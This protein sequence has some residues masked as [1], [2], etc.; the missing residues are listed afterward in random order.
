MVMRKFMCLLLGILVS[1][2]AI[3]AHAQDA[4]S[5]SLDA[6]LTQVKSKGPGYRS[7]ESAV[8]GLER[9]KSQAELV[10]SPQIV[11]RAV[12]VDDRSSKVVSGLDDNYL[13]E[14]AKV[15]DASVGLVKK[16]KFG[17]VV[18]ALDYGFSKG[19]YDGVSGWSTAPTASVTLPLWRDFM[20]RQTRAQMDNM[21]Y[22][23][24]SAQYGSAHQRDALLFQAR[25]TYWGLQLTRDEVE[26]RKDTLA[27]AVSIVKW[28]QR[29]N[30]LRLAEE[31]EIIQARAAKEVREME[32]E[33]AI[34]NER[35][36][37]VAFNR[38]R[39]QEGEDVPEAL[40]PLET[41]VTALSFDWPKE[42]P[43]RWDLRG[44]EAK[45]KADQAAWTDAKANAWPDLKAFASYTAN[46]AGSSFKDS[47]GRSMDDHDPVS[48]VGAAIVIPLDV[49]NA[50][51]SADGYALNYQASKLA[52]DEKTLAARQEWDQLKRRLEDVDKRLTLVTEIE[53]LQ[54]AKLE[55][56]R[57]QLNLGR[58]TQFQ[59]QSYETDYALARLQRLAMTLQ[60]LSVWAEGEWMMAAD[61]ETANK[62]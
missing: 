10:Y 34:E 32:L 37:R 25:N 35:A 60:K 61:R 39:G 5:L 57:R 24:E 6:F 54:K 44:A 41:Q 56:E 13:I 28:A 33:Q 42:S 31:N 30:N 51:K 4:A 48:K 14:H 19:E 55:Q 45:I 1:T 59:V 2:A 62:R 9:Q 43:R 20:G 50:K 49:F 52:Y 27:R 7:A 36:A 17:G 16:W 29:R 3:A 58:S 8:E 15:D 53:K 23:L 46:G 11:A 21:K 38:L 40:I 18:T 22:Q 12:H 26:I 47:H